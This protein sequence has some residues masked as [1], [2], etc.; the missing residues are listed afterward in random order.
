MGTQSFKYESEI[1]V[2][3][4]CPDKECRER[5]RDGYR[6]IHSEASHEDFLP[7]VLLSGVTRRPIDST[8]ME[9]QCISWGLSFFDSAE[10]AKTKF[11]Q[12]ISR[13]PPRKRSSYIAQKGDWIALIQLVP[14]HGKSSLSNKEGHFTLFEYES[15][16]L[17]EDIK[18]KFYIF[19]DNGEP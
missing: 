8:D 5:A 14:R 16:D 17:L 3:D 2:I 1:F 12:I 9:V 19:E 11:S 7:I 6:W 13:Y 18:A 4:N 15:V 10:E